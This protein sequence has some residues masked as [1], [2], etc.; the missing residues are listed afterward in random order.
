MSESKGQEREFQKEI[1]YS[2]LNSKNGL[3]VLDIKPFFQTGQI[4][5]NLTN[6]KPNQTEKVMQGVYYLNV[7]NLFAIVPAFPMF[8]AQATATKK[9]V[10][11]LKKQ[12]GGNSKRREMRLEARELEIL[13]STE[14]NM[15]FTLKI[16]NGVGVKPENGND[17]MVAMA[18]LDIDY[19]FYFSAT[20]FF[21]M[22]EIVRHEFEIY[23]LKNEVEVEREEQEI[24]EGTS[25]T[26]NQSSG[27]P[28]SNPSLGQTRTQNATTIGGKGNDSGKSQIESKP[29][30]EA[31]KEPVGV[32]TTS[33]DG[34]FK[35]DL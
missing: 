9:Y 16:K 35:F 1:Y 2:A 31:L 27:N 18:H 26:G 6:K 7:Y 3:K 23:R 13:F 21:K 8:V 33:S 28:Q 11:V 10:Q 14:R 4:I 20:D 17:G 30:S 34:M 5:F 24:E 22:I 32:S 15:P 25:D 12:G 29:T 19:E